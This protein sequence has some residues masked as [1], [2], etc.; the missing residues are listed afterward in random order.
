[1]LSL[2]ITAAVK[3]SASIGIVVLLSVI[4]EWAGPRVAG[5]A[6]GYPLGAA[7]SLF[8][9]GLEIGPAF[10]AESAIYTTAGLTATLAFVCGYLAGLKLSRGLSRFLAIPTTLLPALLAYGV[11]AWLLSILSPSTLV[12]SLITLTSIILTDRGF[13]SI[14]DAGIQKKIEF[15]LTVTLARAAFAALIILGITAVAGIVGP[16][17]AG[18]FSAFPITMLPLLA[19]I[20]FTYQPA[21]VRAIIKN[22]PHGLG[23]LL[24]YTLVVSAAYPSIGVGWGTITGYGAAT[25][26]LVIREYL[27]GQ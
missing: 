22:V 6:S 23:S 8:F 5:I 14:P 24:V 1:M 13:K 2:S 18:L 25:L 9:I 3:V 20:Q 17:W 26:Y 12:A 19:I 15:S 10:A 21:H 11:V 7:I 27:A 4:A 16:G